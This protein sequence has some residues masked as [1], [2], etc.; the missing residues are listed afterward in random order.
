MGSGKYL[1]RAIEKH[2]LEAF[3]KEILFIFDNEE[4]MNAK[5]A[6]LVTE[7]YC[8]REDTYNLCPGGKGGWG[9]VNQNGLQPLKNPI[10]QKKATKAAIKAL[11][12]KALTEPEYRQSLI[13]SMIALNKQRPLKD[14]YV[15]GFRGKAHTEETKVKMRKS[16]NQG[17]KNSQFGTI[18]INNGVEAKKW[19]GEVPLGWRRG[20][21]ITCL[22]SL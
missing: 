3:E 16:K 22:Q 13:D 9:Y 8:L 17:A 7:E 10:H 20:R 15:N 5:E 21:K 4:E 11:R 14:S 19:R 6:E 12:R 2:G 18:W 1:K